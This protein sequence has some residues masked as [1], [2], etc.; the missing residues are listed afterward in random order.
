MWLPVKKKSAFG[1]FRSSRVRDG[2]ECIM[3]PPTLCPTR[4]K[5]NEKENHVTS[6][7]AR[8]CVLT[9][10]SVRHTSSTWDELQQGHCMYSL[11]RLFSQSLHASLILSLSL[12]H[13]PLTKLH[14]HAVFRSPKITHSSTHVLK[15]VHTHSRICIVPLHTFVLAYLVFT[16]VFIILI[17]YQT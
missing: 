9:T 11:A 16:Q 3:S 5:G 13:L 6:L 14:G 10:D 17:N 8:S 7:T 1:A 15:H 12:N 4:Q 2:Q